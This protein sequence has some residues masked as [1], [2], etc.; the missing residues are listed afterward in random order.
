MTKTPVM[1]TTTPTP[2]GDLAMKYGICLQGVRLMKYIDQ[3]CS[4][5]VS[6]ESNMV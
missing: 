5:A 3:L 6:K 2:L 4:N 1:D